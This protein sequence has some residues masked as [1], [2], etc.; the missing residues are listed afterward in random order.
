MRPIGSLC[1]TKTQEVTFGVE[2]KGCEAIRTRFDG[3]E[4]RRA[5]VLGAVTGPQVGAFRTTIGLQEVVPPLKRCLQEYAMEQ[6]C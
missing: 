5:L 4:L 1:F 2:G 3:S 6:L